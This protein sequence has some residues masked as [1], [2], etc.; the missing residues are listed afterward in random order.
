[1][2]QL[3]ETP[4]QRPIRMWTDNIS[5]D[6]LEQLRNLASMP[7]VDPHGVVAMPDVHVGIGATVGSVIA[8]DRAIIPA[9]VGVDIGC[10]I[11]AVKL[12]LHADDLPDNLRP[13]RLQIEAAIPLGPGGAHKA[14]HMPALD[15]A[16]RDRLR[17]IQAKHPKLNHKYVQHQLG[18]LGSGNHFIEVCLD[19]KDDVWVMLHSGSRGVGNLIGRYFI[20]RAKRKMEDHGHTLPDK[21]LAYL[22]DGSDDFADY[23]EAVQWAQDYAF[24]NRRLM[25]DRTL[26]AMRRT[27]TTPFNVMDEAINCHHNYV[28]KEEHFGRQLWVTRKGAIRAYEGELG[29]IPGSMGQRSYIV[30]G[31]GSLDAYCSCAHGAGREYSR[32]E[33][34][35]RFDIEDL[36]AQTEGVECRKD[37]AVLDELPSAYKDID[38]VMA[39]QEDLVEVVHTLKQVLCVKGA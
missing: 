16:L 15:N 33:A 36:V 30:R 38:E 3:I 27:L 24:E 37:A 34:R 21:N 10:G 5:A 11:N 31:K 7:F 9:A 29:V 8:T 35:K 6:A 12:S 20:E 22:E 4:T 25:M 32:T 19:E 23:V 17:T 13:L 14:K 28:E 18:T 39:N 1:M 26:A 2:K